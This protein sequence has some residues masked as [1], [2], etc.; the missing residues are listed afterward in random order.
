MNKDIVT[1]EVDKYTDGGGD[2]FL[3]E[4]PFDV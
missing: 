1:I 4:I 3:E 2:L